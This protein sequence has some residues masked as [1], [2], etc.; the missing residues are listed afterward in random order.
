MAAVAGLT[1]P[2]QLWCRAAGLSASIVAAAVP[3][4]VL[5]RVLATFPGGWSRNSFG[6]GVGIIVL[7][8]G[9]LV[10][11]PVAWAAA[12]RRGIWRPRLTAMLLVAI[13]AAVIVMLSIAAPF[14]PGLL[15]V[16]L[17]WAPAM[18]MAVAVLRGTRVAL[19]AA[20][21]LVVAVVSMAVPVHLLQQAIV[22]RE[23]LWGNGVPS[24]AYVQVISLPDST[25]QSYQWDRQTSTLT[26]YFIYA[27]PGALQEGWVATETVSRGGN[28]CETGLVEPAE[29]VETPGVDPVSISTEVNPGQW[30]C[31]TDDGLTGYVLRLG[32]LTITLVTSGMNSSTGVESAFLAHHPASDAELWSLTD[33][34]P[35]SL[36]ECIFF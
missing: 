17:Y 6:V 36:A 33:Q 22:A 8:A 11:V 35:Q 9:M 3:L 30:V 12:R 4:A 34:Y 26:A 27:P 13:Q 31:S 32:G 25:Q 16:L 5:I 20:G 21:G 19:S 10:T 18:G 23:W 29:W 15:S 1:R 24:R 7:V 28:P 2:H 14:R